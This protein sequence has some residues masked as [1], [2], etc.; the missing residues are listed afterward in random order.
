[1]QNTN[2]K[3]EILSQKIDAGKAT[4]IAIFGL[5]SVGNFLLNF[6]IDEADKDLEIYVVGRNYDHLV[7]DVNIAKV[8]ASI[9]GLLKSNIIIKE[10]DLSN[11]D[12]IADF[13]KEVEPDFIVN[14]SRAY[15]GIKYGSISWHNVRAYGI[16]TPLSISIIKN[17]MQAHKEAN[18]DAIVINT[19]YSDASNP[20]LKSAGM[21]YPDF[22][23][24]NLNHLVPRIKF[25]VRE[26][27]NLPYDKE[28]DVTIATSH[29]HD[30]VISKEGQSEG[31]DP[32]LHIEVDGK[33][34]ELDKTEIFKK[35]AISMPTDQK[36]NMMNASSNFEIIKKIIHALRDKS[37]NYFASPGPLGSI[38]GYPIKMDG[39]KKEVSIDERFF[40]YDDMKQHNRDSIYL[41]GIENVADGSLIY[42]DELVQK[43]KDVFGVD[44][45]KKVHFSE[46]E[47]TANLLIEKI[48]KPNI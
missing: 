25:A 35:C 9:R 36:R 18:S 39:R 46:I 2:K 3:L 16:W 8:A 10:V 33:E 28:V 47:Q 21:N 43:V 38:G 29:F 40:S 41:D 34:I 4:K 1:M 14:S 45:P 5:G 42:T 20:W 19:S 37:I 30:V 48:I 27:L 7:Q 31:I 22:G 24:G 26:L 23:S 13:M 15:S 6:L 32:L 12:A 44:L 11:V 17:I